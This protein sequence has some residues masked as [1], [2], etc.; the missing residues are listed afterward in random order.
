MYDEPFYVWYYGP[1][2]PSIYAKHCGFGSRAIIEKGKKNSEYSVF[3]NSIVN[4]LKEDL[5]TLVDKSREHEYWMQNKDKITNGVS[6][7]K[8]ELE[9]VLN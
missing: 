5:F 2:V 7:V 1:I 6:T 4:L 3:D 8:Y 9:D